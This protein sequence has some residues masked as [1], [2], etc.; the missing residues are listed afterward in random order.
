MPKTES[1]GIFKENIRFWNFLC[2]RNSIKAQ[3]ELSNN[4]LQ[5]GSGKNELVEK[6]LWKDSFPIAFEI[7]LVSGT[8]Q[9]CDKAFWVL[10]VR[11][12]LLE[13]NVL[14]LKNRAP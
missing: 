1:G 5:P 3:K 6:A 9:S 13:N 10:G 4:V 14:I 8:E 2:F 11:T 7:L 12:A